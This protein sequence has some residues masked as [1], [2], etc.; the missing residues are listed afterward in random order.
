VELTELRRHWNTFGK[1]DPL[2]AILTR[3]NA[4]H[5]RWDVVEF[6]ATGATEITALMERLD[7]LGMP[8]ARR[9]ALDFGC[10]VGRLTQALCGHFEQSV[11]VDIA[12][13][14]IRL[15]RTYNRHGRR[16]HYY[17]NGATDL[18]RFGDDHFDLIYSNLVLQHMRPDLARAYIREFLRVVA[19]DGLVVFGLPSERW[20][21]IGR[22][23]LTTG[24]N[25]KAPCDTA[26]GEAPPDDESA[27]PALSEGVGASEP[28]PDTA[29]SFELA[30]DSSPR[31]VSPGERIALTVEVRNTGTSAWPAHGSASGRFPVS[32]GNHWLNKRGRT[33]IL[34]DARAHL[35]RHLAPLAATTLTMVATAP[36]R[37][38]HYL[39]ELDMVQEGV[40]WFRAK[41]A[42]TVRIPFEVNGA[43]SW[44]ASLRAF[45]SWAQRRRDRNAEAATP[46]PFSPRMEMYG[47]EAET[48]LSWLTDAGADLVDLS[49]SPTEEWPSHVYYVARSNGGASS[50]RARLASIPILPREAFRARVTVLD[51]PRDVTR[52]TDLCLSIIATNLSPV[53]W[54][55][56]GSRPGKYEIRAGNRWLDVEG[57][58]LV[59]DDGRARLDHD[60]SPGME[61]RLALWVRAP[62][63]AGP[64]L[65]EVDLLQE[66][67]AWF[68]TFGSEPA[69][70][71]VLVHE[72]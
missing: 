28:M 62:A 64:H 58:T 44:L 18:R 61:A 45:P 4:R 24:K 46:S 6:F 35:T 42:S 71:Q 54:P 48:V 3:D 69:R 10:G 31:M 30:V 36:S 60:L 41:G 32:L 16:C 29:F 56:T 52:G 59:S 66:H 53:R 26:P 39:L 20:L 70:I 33:V 38:G 43:S 57:R 34:D 2:W 68:Q 15:A 9:R 40:S 17:V 50:T 47:T 5:Q 72:R 27:A 14:M 1:E 21:T 63:T 19:P 11:G 13:S 65:L 23:L 37:P 49:V 25:L 51:P 7:T 55:G 22:P 12:P 8:S 67:V